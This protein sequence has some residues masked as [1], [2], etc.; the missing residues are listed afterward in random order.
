MQLVKIKPCDATF[1][2]DGNNFIAGESNL[3]LSKFTPYPSV[4]FGA[5]FTSLLAH[6]EVFKNIF[7]M[8]NRN[9]HEKILKIGQVYLYNEKDD[10]AYIKAPKDIFIEQ[11]G[12]YREARFINI[13]NKLT[14]HPYKMALE[15][16]KQENCS[17]T[18][19]DFI[20]L[21]DVYNFYRNGYYNGI[22]ILNEK[23]IFVKSIKTGISINKKNNTV[24]DG[25]LYF[26]EQ[27]EFV[28]TSWSYIVEYYIDSDYLFNHY[29][30]SFNNV[31]DGF[32]KL[33]GESKVA[34]IE[35]IM[36][37]EIV[38]FHESKNTVHIKRIMKIVFT[39]DVYFESSLSEIFK[40]PINLIGLVNDKPIYIGGYDM[41]SASS[42]G[43]QV[44]KMYKG[45]S[46][47]T[48]FLIEIDLEKITMSELTDYL[49]RVTVST[50]SKGFG[51][52]IIVEGGDDE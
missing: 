15:S 41:K 21:M 27:T 45:Y 26:I 47:G 52:Y 7:F 31:K 35:N 39:S 48:I 19:G 11:N 34:R 29:G 49:D 14:S 10:A 17:K 8:E 33:G 20:R 16:L 30:L 1:F 38:E 44:R 32:I 40:S 2:G 5:I 4:F 37:S 6:N 46:A 13:D 25:N 3:V 36:N 22:G 9:D 51:Q 42:K 18:E 12:K 24:I 43:S 28:N 50:N 23:N